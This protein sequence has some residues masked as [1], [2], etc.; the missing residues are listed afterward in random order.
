[1]AELGREVNRMANALRG[2]GLGKGDAVGVFM[3]MTPEIVV[4]MLAIIKIG[5]IFL[6]LFSGFGAQAI[7]S[8]L[9]DADAKALFTADACVRRGKTLPLKPVAD[10]AA[11]QIPTLR[12][13]IVL[14]RGGM[15]VNWVPNR[16]H[17]W[18]EL[19]ATARDDS[20]TEPTY[21]E[22]PMMVLYTS[23]TTSRP[24]GAVHTHCGFPIKAPQDISQGLDL[25]PDETLFWVTD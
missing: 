12:H 18:H 3:P 23:G 11:A 7:V 1:Y 4:A 25:H 2:L 17:W 22:D 21:A 24:K 15:A 19:M 8:R 16:D 10:E 13:I 9:T 14:N 20:P 5:G 6:P